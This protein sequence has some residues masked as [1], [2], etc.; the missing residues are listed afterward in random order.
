[1]KNIDGSFIGPGDY[2]FWFFGFWI[3]PEAIRFSILTEPSTFIN[4]TDE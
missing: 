1:M 4:D 2:K 3:H